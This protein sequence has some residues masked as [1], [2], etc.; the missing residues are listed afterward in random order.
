ML[1][2]NIARTRITENMPVVGSED[3]Q[4]AVV[5][6]L[7][8]AD[9]IKLSR[10]SDGE[11]HYIPL[12]WVT[13]V[14]DKVHIDRPGDQ[15]MKEWAASPTE[16][17]PEART[18]PGDHADA[19]VHPPLVARV[20]ARQQELE[21]LLATLPENHHNRGDIELALGSIEGLLTGDP[22]H[23]PAVVAAQM[24]TWLERN[25]HLGVTAVKPPPDVPEHKPATN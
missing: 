13:S 11:H 6:R 14:D 12:A 18:P 17:D 20:K 10:D 4:F 2:H 23:V 8:G 1:D 25:K 19:T 21:A 5:D 16:I 15:A 3:A 7:E 24:S 22:E 9:V